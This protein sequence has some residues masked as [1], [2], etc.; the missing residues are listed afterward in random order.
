MSRSICSLI[1]RAFSEL[2][3]RNF[4][5]QFFGLE[6]G[7]KVFL[8]AH[9]RW[10]YG[11]FERKVLAHYSCCWWPLWKQGTYTLKLLQQSVLEMGIPPNFP[12]QLDSRGWQL[13]SGHLPIYSLAIGLLRVIFCA[14]ITR[15]ILVGTVRQPAFSP[16][17]LLWRSAGGNVGWTVGGQLSWASICPQFTFCPSQ[18]LLDS[19]GT[20]DVKGPSS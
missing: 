15:R 7:L 19:V 11:P 18:D 13:Q 17:V 2:F 3:G 12:C 20:W 4:N 14:E 1:D 16:A 6:V 8:F 9:W 10:W 5:P